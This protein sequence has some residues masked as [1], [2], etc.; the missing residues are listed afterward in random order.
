MRTI[1]PI[2]TIHYQSA[3]AIRESRKVAV[4]TT[5]TAWNAV[6]Q[7]VSLQ[8]H[9]RVDVE[10]ATRDH[11]DVLLPYAEGDVLYAVGGGLA[12]DAAKYIAVHKHVPLVCA[13][14]ALSV[15]AFFTWASGIRVDGCV[16]YVE[17]CCPE[18]LIVD[19]KMIASAPASLRSA[20][21]CD[22]LSIATGNWDWHFADSLGK[23]ARETPLLAYAAQCADGILQGALDCAPAAG[24][25]D[26]AG[27]R[28]LLECLALQ[29]QLC[30]FLGHSR[31]EEGSEHYF[32]YAVEN[33]MGKGMPHGD[34]V[35][36]GILLMASLQGQDIE[37]LKTALTACHIPLTSIPIAVIHETLIHLPDYCIEHNLPFGIAHTL[38]P[39]QV[40][41][42]D[43]DRI[44]G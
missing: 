17:T 23:N 32:A 26:E 33:S 37:P 44:L 27:L 28:Q 21:I 25:G 22:V 13:P 5:A 4:I 1:R 3:S 29:V 31:P 30:N 36:P 9:C 11:W 7:D 38:T 18:T 15:D 35:G 6:K 42:M 2:P 40:D 8:P 24:Q 39:H 12:V 10:E 19:F 20:G 14:T 43:F 16:S 41:N 34:L